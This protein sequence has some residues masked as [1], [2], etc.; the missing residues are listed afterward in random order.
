MDNGSVIFAGSDTVTRS[1]MISGQGN[2][3]QD[4]PGTTI[5]SGTTLIAAAR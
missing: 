1:G 5:L 3:T 4:G 2:V